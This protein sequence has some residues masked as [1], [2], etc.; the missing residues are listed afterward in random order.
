MFLGFTPDGRFL[1]E[2]KGSGKVTL[3]D[4]Q[5]GKEARCL[6]DPPK[7]SGVVSSLHCA[8]LTPDGNLLA[9]S[10]YSSAEQ[11]TNR[12][13]LWDIA[14]GRTAGAIA[15]DTCYA[16]AFSPDGQWLAIGDMQYGGGTALGKI[17]LLPT[18]EIR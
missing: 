7:R 8:A 11:P 10:T 12:I 3:W 14:S 13:T 1:V 6:V 17:R 15:C 9:V 4:A 16:M 18:A 2:A 5:S